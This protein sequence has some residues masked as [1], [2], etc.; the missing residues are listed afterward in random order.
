MRFENCCIFIATRSFG[1][2][3]H[4]CATAFRFSSG[5]SEGTAAEQDFLR[6]HF[7]RSPSETAKNREMGWSY[8]LMPPKRYRKWL[9]NPSVHSEFVLH[10]FS[11]LNH[12]PNGSISNLLRGFSL[13]GWGF[14]REQM[15]DMSKKYLRPNH[16]RES[17]FSSFVCSIVPIVEKLLFPRTARLLFESFTYDNLL[18]VPSPGGLD[19]RHWEF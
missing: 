16:F 9:P 18:S 6:L 5:L 17:A 11:S 7:E 10:C 19:Y 4:F 8:I 15:T 3:A 1:P 2:F 12:G 14:D 13:Y